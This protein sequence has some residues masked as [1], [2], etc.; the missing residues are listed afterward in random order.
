MQ[1]GQ[2]KHGKSRILSAVARLVGM[3]VILASL[4]AFRPLAAQAAGDA[5]GAVYVMT[6]STTGNE[7]LVF[8]R[9]ANG[10]LTPA[11][12]YATG[13]LGAPGLGSQGAVLLTDNQRWLLAVNAGSDQISVFAV[14]PSGL[15]LADTEPS[16]GVRPISVAAHGSLVYVLNAG[17]A[18]NIAGFKLTSDGQLSPLAGSTQPLSN[19][20]VGAA[21]GPAQVSFS[22][23]GGTLVVTEKA[24]NLI[25]TYS[26]SQNGAAA[27]PV[28]HASVGTTPFGFAFGLQG[29]MVVSEAFGGA[30]G[31]SAAS[32]YALHGS[33]LQ[34][35]TAS[36]PTHQTAACWVAVTNN[37]KYAY[38]TNAGSSSITGY[39]VDRDGQLSLLNADGQTGSTGAGSSATDVALSQNSQFMFV[40]AGGSHQVVG[41]AVNADGSLTALGQVAIPAGAA[42]IAAR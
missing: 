14:Q 12:S 31:A 33:S 15:K 16:G 29:T 22:P 25:L 28:T 4:V 35:V 3:V 18:G 42:G 11:G 17:G 1:T 27:A 34:V 21:P 36:S 40:L 2:Q 23:D 20:G 37:G 26:V 13:G 9:A 39:A 6:N 8:D 10:A 38:T 24:T 32:S 7:V 19:G 30:P 41:L 5:P